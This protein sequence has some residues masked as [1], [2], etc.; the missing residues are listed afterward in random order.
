MELVEPTGSVSRAER[1]EGAQL[2]WLVATNFSHQNQQF[3]YVGEFTIDVPSREL[4][5]LL[6]SPC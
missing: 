5:Y 1:L 4:T 2:G 3:M 6:K